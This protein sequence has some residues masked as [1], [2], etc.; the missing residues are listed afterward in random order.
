MF[1]GRPPSK[2]GPLGRGLVLLAVLLPALLPT[3][4][5]AGLLEGAHRLAVEIQ[6]AAA[7]LIVHDEIAVRAAGGEIAFAVAPTAERLSVAVAGRPRAYRRQGRELRVALDPAEVGRS[8]PVAIGYE[9]RFDDPLPVGPV[10]TDNPGYGVSGTVSEA[11]VFILPGA[12]WY[13]A[14]VGGRET[15]LLEVKAPAGMLAVT[16]GE[17]LGHREQGGVTLSTWRVD[18]PVRGLSLSAARWRPRVERHG[19]T[20]LAAYF[21]AENEALAP[22]YLEAAAGYLDLYEALFGPYPFAKF[23]VV[24]NFF[25]TG[26]GFPSYTLIGGGILRLPFILETSLG[27]EIAH[28]WWGNGVFVDPAEGNWSEALTTYTAEH[29]YLERRSAEAAADWRRNALRNYATLAPAGADFPLARFRARIDPATKAV[30]Y[31]KGAMVFHMLRR[32]VGEEAFWGAL[33]DFYRDHL[34]RP[35]GWG[36]LCRAFERRSGRKLA[37]FFDQWTTR[38]GAPA[39]RLEAL[40]REQTGAGWVVRGRLGQEPPIFAFEAEI[41]LETAAGLERATVSLEKTQADFEI[42]SAAEPRR[43][44]VDPESHLLRRLDPLEIPPSV[45]ALRGAEA[46]VIAVAAGMPPE[47]FDLA[48]ALARSLGAPADAVVP[49]A[50]LGG[51]ETTPRD[52]LLIGLP[53][54]PERLLRLPEGVALR[55]EGFTLFGRE[56]GQPGDLFFGV[57][58]SPEA[59][60]RLR[61]I[62]LPIGFAGAEKAAF[63]IPHYG[64]HGYLVFRGGENIDKG[65]WPVETSPVE[66]RFPPPVK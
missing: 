26:Y 42:R 58:R 38:T 6:P 50:A 30:G 56:Y 23:A 10:N 18:H 31:D 52:L 54:G 3:G 8:I 21:L 17:C 20:T 37:R 57:F 27:H 16:A 32:T 1:P 2:A 39:L 19:R 63:K 33:R 60:E 53:A 11:G 62:L 64:R 48:R 4:L 28:C 66:Y 36:D 24:E 15:F 49:E 51:T 14:L 25:P 22:A 7:R 55:P 44:V 45:N 41:G 9:A 46:L 12:G 13:P 61:A 40:H 65:G 35:A 29:L 34:F 43:L 5:R 47:A 59:P